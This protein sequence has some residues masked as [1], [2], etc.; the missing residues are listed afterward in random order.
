M[1]G[2]I[3]GGT[4]TKRDAGRFQGTGVAGGVEGG[5]GLGSGSVR[6]AAPKI[7]EVAV[8][9]KEKQSMFTITGPLKDRK[10]EKQVIPD[11]PA[12]AQSQ[13]I[14]ASVVLEFTVDANGFVKN[15]VV[16]RRTSGYPKLDD[17]AIKALRLWKFVALVG[18]ENREEVGLITFNYSLN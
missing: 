3:P 8:R 13:G 14:E 9:K 4:G 7:N 5:T 16:V 1:A 17:T 18:D 10:I 6:S 11:Y 2:G 12:W 15:N